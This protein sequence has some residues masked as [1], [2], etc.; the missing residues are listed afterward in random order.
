MNF[1]K[2]LMKHVWR[3]QQVGGLLS[4]MMLSI[5]ITFGLMG[6]VTYVFNDLFE[7]LGI[8]EALDYD[9]L[10]FGILAP[11]IFFT[12]LFVGYLYDRT[13]KMWRSQ[14]EVAVE[15]NPYSKTMLSPKEI[16]AWK[17]STI[18]LLRSMG[19]TKEANILNEWIDRCLHENPSL[20]AEVR[21][22]ENWI[23]PKRSFIKEQNGGA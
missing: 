5:T 6:K 11:L 4:V 2:F 1:K 15:R 10:M 3:L 21:E 9:Y 8:P 20:K 16:M 7:G 14:N 22:I 17:T 19:R 18:P 23:D 12:A 13:F